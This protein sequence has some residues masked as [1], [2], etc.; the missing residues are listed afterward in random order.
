VQGKKKRLGPAEGK[1]G[2]QEKKGKKTQPQFLLDARLK[3]LLFRM[4]GGGGTG[5]NKDVFHHLGGVG[6]H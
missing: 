5:P 6:G 3:A 1:G 2:R 4:G